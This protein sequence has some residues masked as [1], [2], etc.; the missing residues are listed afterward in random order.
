MG[1]AHFFLARIVND[2]IYFPP[3]RLSLLLETKKPNLVKT[4]SIPS[5]DQEALVLE[6]IPIKTKNFKL[7]KNI[8]IL[9][10]NTNIW[11]S[12]TN[13]SHLKND[14]FIENQVQNCRI[15]TLSSH[16]SNSISLLKTGEL[17]S[18]SL[19]AKKYTIKFWNI[20]NGALKC[21][22]VRYFLF[23]IIKENHS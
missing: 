9:E 4:E 7:H 18:S 17:V 5:F 20:I 14:Y 21:V 16:T 22:K 1:N 6:K 13:R 23:Y 8:Q 2:F 11:R 3:K 12:N 15:N 19:E 10:S